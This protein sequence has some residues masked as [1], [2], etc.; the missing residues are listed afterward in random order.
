MSSVAAMSSIGMLSGGTKEGAYNTQDFFSFVKRA[1][2]PCMQP[3]P[4]SLSV[5]V[6]DGCSIHKNP[7]LYFAAYQHGFR[8]LMTPPYSPWFN[9]IEEAFSC[10]K[11]F[12]RH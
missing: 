3:F 2:F 5:L 11:A 1:V 7:A 10:F 6:M 8:I 4:G 12:L 9:A